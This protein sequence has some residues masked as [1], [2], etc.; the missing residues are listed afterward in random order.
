MP[1]LP[2]ALEIAAEITP[3]VVNDPVVMEQY[4]RSPIPLPHL[5]MV[6]VVIKSHITIQMDKYFCYTLFIRT[7]QGPVAV[8]MAKIAINR[9][10]EVPLELSQ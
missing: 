1:A 9:G 6:P 10:I 3:K 4:Y 7:L 2:R 8:Q 5:Y